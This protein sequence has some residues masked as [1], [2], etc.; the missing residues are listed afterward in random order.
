MPHQ[1]GEKILLVLA[2]VAVDLVD[3]V[4]VEAVEGAAVPVTKLEGQRTAALKAILGQR[5]Q[6]AI[7]F[8]EWSMERRNS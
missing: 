4:A 1:K 3:L 7:Q 5:L 8:R 2:V 6:R